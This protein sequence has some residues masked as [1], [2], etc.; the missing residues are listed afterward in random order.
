M[1]RSALAWVEILR[2]HSTVG[3]GGA[4]TRP[5][6]VS[7]RL[8]AAPGAGGEGAAA[9]AAAAGV[10][11]VEPS[12][13]SVTAGFLEVLDHMAA[14]SRSV[15]AMHQNLLALL[16]FEPR[17]IFP[18]G[19]GIGERCTPTD[20]VFAQCRAEITSFA[21]ANAAEVQVLA[22]RYSAQARIAHEHK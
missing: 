19:T 14:K 11:A 6:L 22:D 8:S 5:P 12:L 15:M 7:L 17:V 4:G 9:D 20:A 18:L 2:S 1:E 21:T 10:I 16:P 13:E 3:G